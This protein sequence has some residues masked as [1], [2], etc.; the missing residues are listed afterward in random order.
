[1]VTVASA[2][3]ALPS[4]SPVSALTP[5]GISTARMLQAGF[6]SFALLIQPHRR[7]NSE[8]IFPE[9]PVPNKA[10]ISKSAR[11]ARFS[12]SANRRLS[13]ASVTSSTVGNIILQFIRSAAGQ[14]FCRTGQDQGHLRAP[15]VEPASGA[16]AVAAVVAFA[17]KDEDFFMTAG[18]QQFFRRICYGAACIFHQHKTG[19]P[20][21]F[22]CAIPPLP[23][24]W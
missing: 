5:V 1:M 10:S 14:F 19:D 3:T 9:K 7:R 6:F 21:F 4:A 24:Q 13:S 16:A 22:F 23:L 18:A 11:R 8:R 17:G 12:I 2:F 15:I 20:D